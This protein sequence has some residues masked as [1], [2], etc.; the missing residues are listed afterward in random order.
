MHALAVA[1]VDV[2][3]LKGPALTRWLYEPEEERGYAD[4]DLL[5]A[6]SAVPAAESVLAGLGYALRDPEGEVRG[7]VSGPHAQTWWRPSDGA[8]VDLHHTLPGEVLAEDVVWPV[9][10]RRSETLALGEGEVRVL[11][12]PSRSVLV[13][14]H[15]AHHGPGNPGPLEDLRRAAIRASDATWA[16]AALLAQ[17]IMALPRFAEGLALLPEGRQVAQHLRLP[18][19]EMLW[20]LERE[21]LASGYERLA[22]AGGARQRIALLTR[23]VFP[24]PEFM[25]WWAPWARRSRRALSVAYLY[26]IGWLAW[27]AGPG[28]RAWRRARALTRS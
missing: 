13:A 6:P 27:H 22:R 11:D 20:V 21:Q 7:L 9:L 17:S 2:L 19:S 16:E 26:R 8:L 28:W 23:E 12:E 5:V 25:R 4:A 24:P 18:S 3:L 14:L 10:W 15:A 1:G